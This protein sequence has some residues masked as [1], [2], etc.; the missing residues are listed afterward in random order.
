M[1][2]IYIHIPY[3]KTRCTYCDFYTLTNESQMS[4]FVEALCREA[5]TRKEELSETVKTIYFGGGTP[6]RLSREH[7]EQIFE[8]LANQYSIDADAEITVEANPDDLSD[9]YIGM[10]SKLPVNRLSIGIQSFDDEELKFLSRRHTARQ[11]VEAVK[12]CQKQGFSN[13]SIDLMYGLPGQSLELWERNLDQ[14]VALSIQHISAYHLIYEEKTRMYSLLKAGKIRQVD[15]TTSIAMFS[16]LIDRLTAD[17]FIHYEISAFGKEGCFSRH[18]SAYWKGDSY[19]GLGPA[20]HSFNGENRFWNVASLNRYIQS[21]ASGSPERVTEQLK[22]HE[23]YNEFILTGLRTMWG[24][25]L[26]ELKNRFGEQFFQFCM[27]NA[28]KHL[29][30]KLLN[31]DED[32]LKLTRDGIFISDGIMTDLMWV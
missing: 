2:G 8:T 30:Q 27:E 12:K 17:G 23:K 32:T 19:L 31:R 6:S 5:E 21:M 13:I 29:D 11:A 7:F 26:T 9:D 10:L 3:C 22:P 28:Q 20:A 18:N 25:N 16:K 24:I 14:A 1:A 4:T 15:E